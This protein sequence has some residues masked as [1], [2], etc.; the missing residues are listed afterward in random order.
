MSDY[1]PIGRALSKDRQEIIRN[2]K[3]FEIREGHLPNSIIVRHYDPTT[4]QIIKETS[5][6][7]EFFLPK[8]KAK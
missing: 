7:P 4:L 6:K 1:K 3:A 8:P 2:I 5:Y